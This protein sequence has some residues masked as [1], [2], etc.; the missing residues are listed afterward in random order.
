MHL[1]P[2]F[3]IRV[4]GE[5]FSFLSWKMQVIVKQFIVTYESRDEAPLRSRSRQSSPKVEP[6]L[7]RICMEKGD[8]FMAWSMDSNKKGV[9]LKVDLHGF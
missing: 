8:V 5:A 9:Y 6:M 3:L 7:V 4:R 2:G 1:I